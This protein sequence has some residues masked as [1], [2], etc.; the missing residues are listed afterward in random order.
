M[1]MRQWGNGA[2][3]EHER[4]EVVDVAEQHRYKLRLDGERVGL[5]DYMRRH[6]ETH[7]LIA[8]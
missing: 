4:L 6:P 1:A 8:S 2:M 5:A 7:D 3:N